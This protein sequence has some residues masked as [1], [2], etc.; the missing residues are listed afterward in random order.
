[1]DDYS[2]RNYL[3]KELYEYVRNFPVPVIIKRTVKREGLIQAR[4][5]GVKY[6]TVSIEMK[7]KKKYASKNPI[8]SRN[9]I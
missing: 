9:I 2:D 3:L 1:M 8:V 7:K 4:L 5:L 6:A